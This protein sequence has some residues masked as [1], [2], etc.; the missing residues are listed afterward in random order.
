MLHPPAF[1][2]GVALASTL[3]AFIPITASGE[4]PGHGAFDDP[5]LTTAERSAYRAT[6]T[7][8]EVEALA[9][10]LAALSDH[11]R[12]VDIGRSFLDR[13][14][15]MLVIA[16]ESFFTQ[17]DRLVVLLQCN[18]HA[19][20]VCG[21]EAS[22][23]LARELAHDPEHPWLDDTVLLVVPNMNPDGND[24][25]SPDNRP[26][27]LGPE[28]GMGTRANAQSLDL[29]R[30]W[31]KLASP[32]VRA[33]V[34]VL[35]TWDPHLVIDAHAT[36][37]SRHRYHLTY[38]VPLN[39]AGFT[40]SVDFLRDTLLPEVTRRLHG[41]TGLD[42][43]YYGNFNREHTAW[44]TYSAHPRHGGSYCGLR[45]VMNILSEACA[46]IPFEA[47][48]TATREFIRE[49]IDA[50]RER[51]RRILELHQAARRDATG[52]G[53]DPQP[54]DV[55]SIRH[56]PAAHDRLAH[57]KGFELAETP[58]GRLRPT[59][60]PAD[61][62][63]VHIGR[64]EPVLSVP[65]PFGYVLE[66]GLESALGTLR[67][68][69]VA[70]EPFDGPVR[71]ESWIPLEVTRSEAPFQGRH[72]AMISARAVRSVFEAPPGSWVV[73]TA[74][75]L[76][77]LVVAL[78]EPLAEDGLVSWSETGDPLNPVVGRRLPVHRIR[79][80]E[81]LPP[82]GVPA[83]GAAPGRLH[84]PSRPDAHRSRAGEPD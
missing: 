52:R 29:N 15:P 62:A 74:Q 75:P 77:T 83:D 33:I 70:L 51:R 37:G 82:G 65:R 41:R 6:S 73:R 84:G 39:P 45:G 40:P 48:V 72:P 53:A 61:H 43:F 38:D 68:H 28:A 66:P 78:L 56:R 24:R 81:D 50:A 30:D 36:N 23:Q 79:H 11:I 3:P 25:M 55:V 14:I 46:Y 69:G 58:A 71:V 4:A 20:E 21:K 63:V 32:E 54:H 19:G 22:L 5:L 2:I 27:Q 1:A 13:P 44:V 76:G 31:M 57:V 60:V 12:R 67:A 80:P 64:F 35:N 16:R 47:R 7:S 34:R 8:D 10:R 17:P 42:T 26:G 18:I 49:V 59:E 9:D